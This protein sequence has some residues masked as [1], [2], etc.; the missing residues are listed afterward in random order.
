MTDNPDRKRADTLIGPWAVVGLVA[1]IVLIRLAFLSRF[2]EIEA[3]EGLWTNSPKNFVAFGDWFMDGRKHMF[4]SPAFSYGVAGLF[5]LL[6]PSIAAARVLSALAGAASVWL[7]YVTVRGCTGKNS[8]ALIAALLFGFDE[9]SI[10]MSRRALVECLELFFVLGAAALFVRRDRWKWAGAIMLA[11]ALLAKTNAVVM[12]AVFAA[13]LVLETRRPGHW[14]ALA[15]VGR[16]VAY[17]LLALLAA[18]AAYGLL[19]AAHPGPFVDAFRFELDGVHFEGLSHPL[20]RVGRFGID[21]I[22]ASRTVIALFRES[23]LLMVLFAVG[24]AIAVLA[25][26]RGSALFVPWLVIGSVFLLG[27]MFQPLRYFYLLAPAFAFFATVTVEHLGRTD[28][29]GGGGRRIRAAAVAVYLV[30]NLA[31]VAAEAAASRGTMLKQVVSWAATHA[32]ADERIMAAGYLC[33]DLPQ[34]AYAHYYFARNADDLLDNLRKYRIDY[35]IYDR[36]EW[37]PELGEALAAHF[38]VV[39]RFSFGAVYR[40]SPGPIAQSAPATR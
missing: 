36:G 14:F 12:V 1:A 7:L 9:M 32:R 6:G 38:P 4:L 19:Y 28:A 10:L 30:F 37:R 15:G 16:A 34:R 2:P 8:T 20:L 27:Q 21:P 29:A 24:A 11:F 5:S 35:V 17:S 3:D 13:Y 25:R 22:Q 33:T 23:P 18:G 40:C 39:Q 31:Y 26:P